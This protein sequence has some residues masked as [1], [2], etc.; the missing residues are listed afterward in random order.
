MPSIKLGKRVIDNYS[1]PYII[2]E[3]G[4]NHEG[5]VETAKKLI[6]LA[7]KGGADAAKFQSYKADSLASK[8]SPA[9]WDINEEP[10]RSQNELFKKYDCFN[11]KEYKILSAHCNN[12]EI[13]FLS[14]PFDVSSMEFLEPL[15]DFYKIASADITNT[16]FLRMIAKK[17]KPVV[18]STGA[19]SIEEIKNAVQILE[20]NGCSEIALLHCILN[21]PT[22]DD[23]A[24]LD[25][26][27]GL[28]N[29]FPR[30]VIG[31]SDHTLPNKHMTPLVSAYLLGAQIIEKHFTN[32]KNLPGNDHYHSM[33]F[34]NLKEFVT[35]INHIENLKGSTKEKSP[36]ES[37]EIARKNAR[38][39]IVLSKN[40]N[41]GEK[42]SEGN[43][44]FKRP[45]TGIS[46]SNWDKII[47]RKSL[48]DLKSDHILKW[49]DISEK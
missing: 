29:S 8:K 31:Y 42:F 34:D 3:I 36:I 13:D 17:N 26:I 32:D 30:Y 45:G 15:M 14:T 38:R 4:V 12:L 9:Y 40:I 5:S 20:S 21:Y 19:S 18:L 28:K 33:D 27:T 10:T 35:I 6:E 22:L 41:S 2:A 39:S 47:G 25:M 1:R 44:T 24:H 16:P 23:N 7:K 46:S 37:E 43:L 48:F 11:E 49:T